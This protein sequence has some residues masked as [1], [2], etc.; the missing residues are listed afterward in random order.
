[1]L[2]SKISGAAALFL[3]LISALPGFGQVR[4][5][6]PLARPRQEPCWQVAG[7]S[8][9]AM[10]ERQAIARETRAEVQ[11]VCTD[12]SLNPQQK[13]TK[14]REIRQAAKQKQE[15]LV[16]PQ[17]L[18]ALQSCQRQRAL[19]RPPSGG[20]HAPGIGPCGEVFTPSAKPPHPSPGT[21]N[22]EASPEE[23]NQPQ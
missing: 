3:F 7:I 8:R 21:S 4:R 2:I 13:R 11:S 23:E 12:S 18:E 5:P 10:Q 14:I 19:N 9:A 6:V 22:G 15:A 16:T 1:M 17:Q 20:M